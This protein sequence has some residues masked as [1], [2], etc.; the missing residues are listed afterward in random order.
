MWCRGELNGWKVW[1]LA[2][3]TEILKLFCEILWSWQSTVNKKPI[4]GFTFPT[5][6]PSPL[7]SLLPLRLQSNHEHVFL[8]GEDKLYLCTEE[9]V[10]SWTLESNLQT[11]SSST[12]FT[13]N[14]Q[15]QIVPIPHSY[16]AHNWP[17]KVEPLLERYAL[18][19][20]WNLCLRWCHFHS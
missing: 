13:G 6:L 11:D 20:L 4:L 18:I 3:S 17:I 19:F 1:Q 2:A 12:A 5:P 8:Q 16:M 14:K 10:P 7:Q 15:W 9:T